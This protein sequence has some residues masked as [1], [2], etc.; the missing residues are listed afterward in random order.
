MTMRKNGIIE[1]VMKF[2]RNAVIMLNGV[3]TVSIYVKW[4]LAHYHLTCLIRKRG[5]KMS[6]AS[7]ECLKQKQ[8][9]K[10]DYWCQGVRWNCLYDYHL[11]TFTRF[12][13]DSVDKLKQLPARS[14]WIRNISDLNFIWVLF[15][16]FHLSINSLP[17]AWA[18]NLCIQHSQ[19]LF[20]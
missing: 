14:P 5:A 13:L 2:S 9:Q 16:S 1:N 3:R 4:I 12:N 17:V 6:N 7:L 8:R 15:V 18:F 20:S 19:K 11:Q 10:L